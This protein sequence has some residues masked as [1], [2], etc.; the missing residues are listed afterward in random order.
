MQ[1]FQ[2]VEGI[3]FQQFGR[4]AWRSDG[5]PEGTVR[6]TDLA[7]GPASS[8]PDRFAVV[9]DRLFFAA[10]DLV[11]GFELFTLVDPALAE[12]FRDG[13]ESGGLTRWSE[14]AP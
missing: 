4:E 6:I 5:T 12:I 13:F 10:N 1:G 3:A 14:A 7:P 2:R 11:H 8:S 9:G